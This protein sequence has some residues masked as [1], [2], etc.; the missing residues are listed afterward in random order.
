MCSLPLT[1]KNLKLILICWCTV[2]KYVSHTQ[3]QVLSE[4]VCSVLPSFVLGW[5]F[6]R[7]FFYVEK[8]FV[9]RKVVKLTE[10]Q[11]FQVCVKITETFAFI[12]GQYD[13]QLKITREI[14]QIRWGD[15]TYFDFICRYVRIYRGL[16]IFQHAT[17]NYGMFMQ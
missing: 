9:L 11:H 2:T 17:R 4:P 13:Y 12:Q 7:N 8:D 15:C 1:Y 5:S 10:S 6:E 16:L 3:S 14:N